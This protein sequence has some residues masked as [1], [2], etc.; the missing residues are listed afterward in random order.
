[1]DFHPT[2]AQM[3]TN[4]PSTLL[5]EIIIHKRAEVAQQKLCTPLEALRAEAEL[6]SPLRDFWAALCAP[7]VSLIAEVKKASPS[8]GLLC[9][10]FDPATL[11]RTYADNGAAAISVLT[12][13]HFFQGS[14][15]DLRTVRQTVDLPVLRKD[16]IIDLYQV[17]ESRIAGADAVLLIVAALDDAAL[18]NL[19]A[20]TRHLGMAALVEVHNA[21]EL[22]RATALRPRII[23]IN[24]RNLQTFDVSLDTTAALRPRIPSRV[25]VIAESG[26]HTAA[27]V[28]RLA[29]LDVD[30]MLVGEALVTAADVGAKVRELVRE[31]LDLPEPSPPHL[32][33]P[34][35]FDLPF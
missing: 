20:L 24:N 11:A 31:E 34:S 10:T 25:T 6:A 26:I 15:D 3:V 2:G 23:G 35:A 16:F 9:P 7:G 30:A 28:D 18:H 19:Y 14:L 13:E 33:K 17:Y 21:N 32:H 5:D 1:M 12:D 27:D 4:Q 22:M 29:G 8:K